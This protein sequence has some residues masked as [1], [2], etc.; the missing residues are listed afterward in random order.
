MQPIYFAKQNVK[1]KAIMWIDEKARYQN[2]RKK[3]LLPP[4]FNFFLVGGSIFFNTENNVFVNGLI[5][6][7]EFAQFYQSQSLITLINLYPY[8]FLS[9]CPINLGF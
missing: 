6:L 8:S 7:V 2:K 3:Q 4:K 1:K 9:I 5:Y